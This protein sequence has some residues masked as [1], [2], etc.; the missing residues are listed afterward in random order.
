MVSLELVLLMGLQASGK[1]SFYKFRFT[2]THAHV[3]KDRL[4]NNRRPERRQQQLIRAALDEGLNVVVDNTNPTKED[5]ASLIAIGREYGAT[6]TGYYFESSVQD[7]VERNQERPEKD[8][9]PQVAIYS[10]IKRLER[11]AFDEGFDALYFV[12][13]RAGGEFEVCGWSD[14]EPSNAPG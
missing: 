5:R 8:R 2:E 7:C 13:L 12:R 14:E 4:K 9:V 6:V 1:T 10:T 11:P 3:S